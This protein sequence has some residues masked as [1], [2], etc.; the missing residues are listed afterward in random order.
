MR[1]TLATR[2]KRVRLPLRTGRLDLVLPDDGLIP[3]Y[4]RLM[5]DP[6]I[7]RM[8]LS[9]PYPYRRA[10]ARAFVRRARVRYRAGEALSLSIKLRSSGEVI[11]GVGLH[12]RLVG[13]VGLHPPSDPHRS[14]AE[15]GYWL[16]RDHRGH[17][18]ATEAVLALCDVA[19]RRLR[20]HRVTAVV[21]EGNEASRRVVERAGFQ[22]EGTSREATLKDGAWRSDWRF[23]RLVG[24]AV[25]A[26]P[27]VR[28]GRPAARRSG[29]PGPSARVRR[30]RTSR[31]PRADR[32]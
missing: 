25:P 26:R 16:G 8:T 32:P 5:N 2:V 20:V 21:F 22:F 19:F 12:P 13:S 31:G 14:E 6:E 9:M 30:P 4:L 17:G 29:G 15:I 3:D 10:H 23:A 11:G 27:R 18:Y 24:D 7:S 28:T 1:S